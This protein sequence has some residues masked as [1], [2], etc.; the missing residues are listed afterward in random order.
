VPDIALRATVGINHVRTPGRWRITKINSVTV[1]VEPL[2][3]QRGIGPVSRLLITDPPEVTAAG[4]SQ[5]V[6]LPVYYRRGQ[7]VCWPAAPARA[8]GTVFVVTSDPGRDRVHLV[9]PGGHVG[10]GGGWTVYRDRI[11]L[12]DPAT[13]ALTVA[14]ESVPV[15]AAA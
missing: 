5:T 14:G 3:G 10:P 4:S 13:I 12:I 15:T 1:R 8:H 2:D 6:D 11:T 9:L 7:F